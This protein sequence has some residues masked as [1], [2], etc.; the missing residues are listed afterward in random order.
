MKSEGF[1]FLSAPFIKKSKGS[2]FLSVSLKKNIRNLLGKN[3]PSLVREG[4]GGGVGIK[5]DPIGYV[6]TQANLDLNGHWLIYL[7]FGKF[8]ELVS[9]SVNQ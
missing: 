1:I 6:C 5:D 8:G 9:Q 3:M 7:F 2:K 4:G